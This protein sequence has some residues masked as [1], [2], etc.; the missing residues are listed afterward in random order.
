MQL[1]DMESCN[2][3][4]GC[5]HVKGIAKK[6]ESLL[7]PSA[8][9]VCSYLVE[10]QYQNKHHLID[11]SE[12]SPNKYHTCVSYHYLQ[13]CIRV[14]K[15]HAPTPT[16]GSYTPPHE[17]IARARANSETRITKGS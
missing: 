4:Q 16:H 12:L 13:L 10:S 9:E 7:D 3:P 17:R 11:N 6:L 15:A 14:G 5:T 2:T 1:R 8:H